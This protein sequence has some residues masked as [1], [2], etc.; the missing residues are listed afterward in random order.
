MTQCESNALG[1]GLAIL[2][3]P[4]KGARL[5]VSIQMHM[6]CTILITRRLEYWPLVKVG[7]HR[8]KCSIPARFWRLRNIL[9]FPD[10]CGYGFNQ[11]S[12]LT[13]SLVVLFC[14]MMLDYHR[15]ERANLLAR[16]KWRGNQPFFNLPGRSNDR[17]VGK[18][19]RLSGGELIRDSNWSGRHGF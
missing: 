18:D 12:E 9:K 13:V 17:E 15:K 19:G 3:Q 6:P 8:R 16:S 10:F 5:S 11:L 4:R 7:L 1:Y 14:W 2:R